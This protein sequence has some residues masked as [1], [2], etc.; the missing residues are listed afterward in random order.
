MEQTYSVI[1]I[2]RAQS[3]LKGKR[4]TVMI[5][6]TVGGQRAELSLKRKVEADRWDPRANRVKGSKE[7]A[8][9]INA[10][11]ENYLVKL[12]RIHRTLLEDAETI[13]AEGSKNCALAILNPRDL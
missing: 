4:A 10:L 9:E 12:N 1:P 13:S 7:D 8:R 3:R 5:R 11:I 6:I 2:L